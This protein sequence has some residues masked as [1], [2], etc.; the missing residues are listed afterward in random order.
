M[1]SMIPPNHPLNRWFTGLVQNAMYT[2]L[3]VGD[4]PMVEYLAGLLVE[5]VGTDS[6]FALR[7]DVGRPIEQ[8]ADMLATTLVEPGLPRVSRER[9][10]HRHIG[11]FTLFWT[12]LFPEALKRLC[13]KHARDFILDYHRQ[14]KR[15]YAIASELTPENSR[16]PGSV[17]RMLSEHFDCCV[18]GLALVRQEVRAGIAG[19]TRND[20]IIG[21]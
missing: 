21:G 20:H 6:I 7:D 13:G 19:A 17:L 8:V 16:P 4:P 5:F 18:E 2:E 1:T 9:E 14:G 15:S 11:D 12:G 10:V 3:G